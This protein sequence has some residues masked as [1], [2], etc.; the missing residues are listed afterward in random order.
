MSFRV[1]L[2]GLVVNIHSP[3][4]T[5]KNSPCLTIPFEALCCFGALGSGL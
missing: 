2:V 4:F 1:A 5:Q 3:R